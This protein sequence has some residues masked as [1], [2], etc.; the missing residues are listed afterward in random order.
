MGGSRVAMGGS[1]VAMA[2]MP[3]SDSVNDTRGMHQ[4]MYGSCSPPKLKSKDSHRQN[5]DI[6]PKRDHSLNSTLCIGED[7]NLNVTVGGNLS[8]DRSTFQYINHSHHGNNGEVYS[9]ANS[10]AKELSSFGVNSTRTQ[11][12]YRYS[13]VGMQHNGANI[14]H[15]NNNRTLQVQN[16]RGMPMPSNTNYTN[17]KLSMKKSLRSSQIQENKSV[18]DYNCKQNDVEEQ[19]SSILN[20]KLAHGCFNNRCFKI[21]P[22]ILNHYETVATLQNPCRSLILQAM[23]IATRC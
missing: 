12:D 17:D 11:S 8:E 3:S 9:I 6:C 15:K 22:R 1:R 10:A 4:G 5:K 23:N 2:N 16:N 14:H 20:N 18:L 21:D 19:R 7:S 13:P